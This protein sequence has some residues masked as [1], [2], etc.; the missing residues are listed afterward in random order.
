MSVVAA[1]IYENKIVMASDSIIIAGWS[2]TDQEHFKS[3]K[4]CKTNGMLVGS[5]GYLQEGSMFQ[6]FCSNHKPSEAKMKNVIEFMIEFKKWVKELSLN[7][8]DEAK[9]MLENQYMLAFDSTLWVIDGVNVNQVKDFYAIGAG[10]DFAL[11]AMHLGHTPFEAVKLACE[12][13]CYV[14]EPILEEIIE[15]NH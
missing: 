3:V 7:S 2:R 5:C 8:D 13:S 9:K 10:E 14:T 4:M 15:I 6:V 11:A 1:R 12:M